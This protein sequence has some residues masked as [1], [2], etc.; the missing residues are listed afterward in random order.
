MGQT[1]W[2]QTFEVLVEI[3]YNVSETQS[4]PGTKYTNA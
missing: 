2:T 1:N 3:K 4:G